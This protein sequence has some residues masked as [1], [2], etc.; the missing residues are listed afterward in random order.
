MHGRYTWFFAPSS[1]PGRPTDSQTHPS[2]I[3]RSEVNDALTKDHVM[4]LLPVSWVYSDRFGHI[5]GTLVSFSYAHFNSLMK[6][7]LRQYLQACSLSRILLPDDDDRELVSIRVHRWRPL[8]LTQ[9][10]RSLP[11]CCM[12][13][14]VPTKV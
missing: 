5:R 6:F 10:V 14:G 7:E 8:R 12:R 9:Q 11:V 4:A 3:L 13:G 2:A 1:T